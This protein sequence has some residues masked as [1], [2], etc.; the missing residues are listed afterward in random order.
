[1]KSE[2]YSNS[3]A[4]SVSPRHLILILQQPYEITLL[5]G[6]RAHKTQSQNSTSELSDSKAFSSFII[7]LLTLS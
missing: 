3:S 4:Q 6:H 7:L 5:K 2:P 1:M